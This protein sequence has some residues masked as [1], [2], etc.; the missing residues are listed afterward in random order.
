M[1][2]LS[3]MEPWAALIAAGVKLS[4]IHIFSTQMEDLNS[5]AFWIKKVA[6]RAWRPT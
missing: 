5:L 1:Q 6:G 4:L 2:A 3:L